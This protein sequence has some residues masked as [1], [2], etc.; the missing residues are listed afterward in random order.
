MD[1]HWTYQYWKGEKWKEGDYVKGKKNGKWTYWFENGQVLMEGNFRSDLEDGEWKS[2]YENGNQ[3]DIGN[4][5]MGR[6]KGS[7]QGFYPNGVR[8]YEGSWAIS[9]TEDGFAKK[10]TDLY[11]IRQD[12]TQTMK[13]GD[14]KT[15][16]W[17]YWR[18]TGM[19]EK[20]ETYDASGLLNGPSETYN[21][22][23]K[24]EGKGNYKDGRPHG[25]WEYFHPYGTPMRA[26]NY[27][28]GKLD[29]KST[30]FDERGRVIEESNYKANKLDGMYISY[31]ERTGKVRL[32][33][34]YEN[35]RVKELLEGKPAG[36]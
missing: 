19:I 20:M 22:A 10:M 34:I 30:V 28:Q 35:G 6:M 36:K 13:T 1:G 5:Q 17:T 21:I 31:D 33:Q 2:W 14:V 27:D 4:Y 18:E 12:S 16:K 32:K 26:C 8:N 15:G 29:G 9:K 23:G 11:N 7:W 25:K 3:K 24:I